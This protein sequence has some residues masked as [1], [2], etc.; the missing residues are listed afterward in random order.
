MNTDMYLGHSPELIARAV[1]FP[2][3]HFVQLYDM[4]FQQYGLGPRFAQVLTN[5]YRQHRGL[6]YA[7]WSLPGTNYDLITEQDAPKDLG[8]FADLIANRELVNQLT[9]TFIQRTG[10]QPTPAQ[11]ALA[12]IRARVETL[13]IDDQLGAHRLVKWA[14]TYE[15][16]AHWIA[17]HRQ[18]AFAQSAIDWSALGL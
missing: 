3:G 2:H 10:Q 16:R 18:Q 17:T 15:R 11:L 5:D 1:V 6:S 7:F 13:Q 14:L 12:L 4:L 8:S 9:G